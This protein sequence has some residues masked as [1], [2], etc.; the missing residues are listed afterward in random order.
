MTPGDAN[1]EQSS[2]GN[3][4]ETRPTTL[5]ERIAALGLQNQAKG[6]KKN[7]VPGNSSDGKTAS[8]IRESSP[9]VQKE[10]QPEKPPKPI[11]RSIPQVNKQQEPESNSEDPFSD[12]SSPQP[13]SLAQYSFIPRASAAPALPPKPAL[14]KAK[15]DSAPAP[16]PRPS[17]P[18]GQDNPFSHPNDTPP[19]PKVQ[20][21]LAKPSMPAPHTSSPND[22]PPIAPRKPSKPQFAKSTL[23]PAP[24][25]PPKPAAER[26][27]LTNKPRLEASIDTSPNPSQTSEERFTHSRKP[28]FK[29]SKRDPIHFDYRFANRRPPSLGPS[30]IFNTKPPAPG[31]ST[32]PN[33]QASRLAVALGGP[34]I[35]FAYHSQL[36]CCT[37]DG[38]DMTSLQRTSG[39]EERFTAIAPV[40]E[41]YDPSEH[42]KYICVGTN[43]GRLVVMDASSSSL[44]HTELQPET[45]VPIFRIIAVGYDEVWVIDE[46]FGVMV[47]SITK[48]PISNTPSYVSLSGPVDPNPKSAYKIV[49]ACIKAFSLASDMLPM[50]RVDTNNTFFYVTRGHYMW[51]AFDKSLLIYDTNL[52]P[53]SQSGNSDASSPH[54]AGSAVVAHHHL[55]YYEGRI[56]SIASNASFVSTGTTPSRAIV[57]TGLDRGKIMTWSVDGRRRGRLLDLGA[58]YCETAVT[59]LACSSERILWVGLDTG[60][61]LVVDVGD[62]CDPYTSQC[63]VLKEWTSIRNPVT[64]IIVDEFTLLSE[65]PKL[66]VCSVHQNGS[67]FFWDGLLTGD[68]YYNTMRSRVNEYCTFGQLKVLVCSWN[69]DALKPTNLSESTKEKNRKH[70]RNWFMALGENE[71][72]DILVVGFQEVVDLE[73]K[74]MTMKSL[75]KSTTSKKNSNH[76]QNIS[77]RYQL[78]QDALCHTLRSTFPD[79]SYVLLACHNLVGLFSCIFVRS[80]HKK[81][82]HNVSVSQVKTGMGGL[83]GNKGGIGV[84]FTLY[85]TSFCFVVSHLAA[86]ESNSN[87]QAR[88]K[89]CATIIRKIQFKSFSPEYQA[90][91]PGRDAHGGGPTPV[92]HRSTSG[93]NPTAQHGSSGAGHNKGGPTINP[94]LADLSNVSLDAFVDGGD[95]RSYLDH[96][97]CFFFGDLNYRLGANRQQAEK[98]IEANNI[99][100]M[101]E[102]DQL[103]KRLVQHAASTT[104]LPAFG[105]ATESDNTPGDDQ[106]ITFE[107]IEEEDSQFPLTTFNESAIEFMPT[108]KY[109]PGTDTYDTS[110]KQRVP[111]WCDRVLYRGGNSSFRASPLP[112]P[113]KQDERNNG[114]ITLFSDPREASADSQ[115]QLQPLHYR[116]YECDLSD[117]RPISAGFTVVVKS[118][119]RTEREAVA[120]QISQTWN[121]HLSSKIVSRAKICWLRRFGLNSEEA[122]NYLVQA[123]GDVI[124]AIS[125]HFSQQTKRQNNSGG[126]NATQG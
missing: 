113:Q 25:P 47:W 49:P 105:I 102:E 98:M 20:A 26:P 63:T 43:T 46:G 50:Y 29:A 18:Q 55:D 41:V 108:Y 16:Q 42:G 52:F 11:Q 72:P 88:D 75:W 13:S 60:C 80:Q 59:A 23:P 44:K 54:S 69:I 90:I 101:L 51:V 82:V 120:R 76:S 40:P 65:K 74:K 62:I 3:E 9:E 73:S 124:Q 10:Y 35:S 64:S 123:G 34:H 109:D 8:R 38:G 121:N 66:Q 81:E 96:A 15:A 91:T 99:A 119:S 107:D 31:P 103:I 125:Y 39:A 5:A 106:V 114:N 83:H 57:F 22:P 104:G 4:E 28:S 71:K 2:Q 30:P 110:E 56:R 86:G 97:V 87:I 32:N 115:G 19:K 68:H 6:S 94:A 17:N 33:L 67:I 48:H 1:S 37:V 12:M 36:R 27:D 21:Q 112:A 14:I 70:L 85:D 53:R 126:G 45:H 122:T 84:R 78:W 24:P 111:A 93:L 118:I 100:A 116:R 95:G 7:S 79:E 89:H 92:S 61:V 77:R 117:H 58:V